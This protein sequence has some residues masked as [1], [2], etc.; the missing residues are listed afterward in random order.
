VTK[1][2]HGVLLDWYATERRD[3]PWREMGASA[4]GVLVSE[5]MLQQTPV[6]RVLPVYLEWLERWPAPKDLASVPAGEAVRAWGRLGYPRRALR[7]HETACILTEKHNGEVPDGIDALLKLPGIG[8]YTAAAVASFA[9]GQRHPVLDTNVRR[10]FAR[11][12]NGKEFP[13]PTLSV[14]ETRLAESLLPA[15]PAVAARWSVAVMELGALICTSARPLCRQCPLAASCSWLLSGRPPASV[16]PTGQKY[17]G[18]DRQCRGALL[19]ILRE[20]AAP[21]PPEHLATAWPDPVRRA[22]ALDTLVADGLAEVH[23]NG[24]VSLPT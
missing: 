13:G 8:S 10:V 18:T 14:A 23:S 9:F 5:V 12:I 2:D 21:V 6:A 11:L 22:R 7:L 19:A 16:R 1:V 3:L 17:E 24:S 15:T 4:W 20:A